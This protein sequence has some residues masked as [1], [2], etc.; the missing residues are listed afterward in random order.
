MSTATGRAGHAWSRRGTALA[1]SLWLC[2]A[3]VAQPPEEVVR[4]SARLSSPEAILPG[5]T[6]SL[7]VEATIQD[8][9][10]VY[11]LEQ[12]PGGPTPLRVTLAD[13]TLAALDGA[14]SGI[15]PHKVY[16]KR[17]GLTT[18]LYS[19]S[20]SLRVPVRMLPAA[21]PG[22]QQLEVNVR[23]QSCSEQECRPPKTVR[24]SVAVEVSAHD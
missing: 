21:T 7:T 16:D 2:A 6:A 20:L 11:A 22:P 4:W 13:G 9:W 14:P 8:G 10:H 3:A 23:F 12:L 18:Q 1:V 15:K 5:G 24:L 19:R 17:F